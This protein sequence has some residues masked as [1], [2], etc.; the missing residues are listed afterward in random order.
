MIKGAKN[1]HIIIPKN[2]IKTPSKSTERKVKKA[3]KRK[4]AES[5]R[6]EKYLKNAKKFLHPGNSLAGITNDG[7]RS[8][9]SKSNHKSDL[10]TLSMNNQDSAQF[11]T[12]D[13][14]KIK[15]FKKNKR[16]NISNL[17]KKIKKK[18]ATDKIKSGEYQMETNINLT[19]C[20]DGDKPNYKLLIQNKRKSV[21]GRLTV[22]FHFVQVL[23]QGRLN[24]F[25]NRVYKSK[26]YNSKK[27]STSKNKSKSSKPKYQLSAYASKIQANNSGEWS[28]NHKFIAIENF[29]ILG[30]AKKDRTN[31]RSKS[32][33][34]HFKDMDKEIRAI[35][36]RGTELRKV[37][38]KILM[39]CIG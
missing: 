11:A 24:K 4:G 39:S 2:S 21:E 7:L 23:T 13:S 16:M 10:N 27:R 12:I 22:W 36:G 9:A 33:E 29:K 15:I 28:S 17:S 26:H 37:S 19:N 14:T 1:K 25:E 5:C 31:S 38:L 32:R 6:I 20:K 8:T 3:K 34:R 35:T 30:K 18:K